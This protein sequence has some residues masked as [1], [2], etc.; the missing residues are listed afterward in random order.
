MGVADRRARNDGAISHYIGMLLIS[1]RKERQ[2]R[3]QQ[4]VNFDSL[5]DLPSR[6]L[7]QQR[8]PDMLAGHR[9]ADSILGVLFIDLDR[10]K[11]I[12]DTFGH[13][14]SDEILRQVATRL[15][16]CIGREDLLTATAAMNSCWCWPMWIRA[17]ELAPRQPG[18]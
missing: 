2:A 18:A 4:L 1:A 5:T 9:Y 16:G 7:L 13:R 12:A 14:A 8:L 11:N 3:V 10:F 17:T 15:Q 6:A